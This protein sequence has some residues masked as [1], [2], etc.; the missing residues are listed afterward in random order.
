MRR[1][2][3]RRDDEAGFTLVELLAVIG[4][5]AVLAF[6]LTE[7]FIV[8]MKTT[9]ANATDMYRSVGV[10]A[11]Q[12]YFMGDVQSA[13]AVSS[14]DPP[15]TPC[16]GAAGVFL[17]L[18]WSNQG[19]AR[20]VSYSVEDVDLIKGEA[21]L[22]RSSCT[23]GGTADKKPLGRFTFDPPL[24]VLAHCDGAPCPPAPG[25]PRTV[26]LRIPTDR[27]RESTGT[28]PALSVDLTVQR[29]TAT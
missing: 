13:T 2:P 5:L 19:V 17:H 15:S 14:P 29:R 6:P 24:P 11:V 9:D 22:V 26:T 8:G 1:R 7:A 3:A 10:Q 25:T 18:S 27:A 16:A 21:E 20:D 12:S 28:T 23:G 4:I